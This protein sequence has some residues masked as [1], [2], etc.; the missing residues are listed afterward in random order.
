MI[1]SLYAGLL[2]LLFF[3]I[4]METIK[5]RRKHQVSLGVGDHHEVTAMVSAHSNFTSYAIYFLFLLYLAE[6]SEVIPAL[7]LHLVSIVFLA[8]RLFHFSAFRSE[9]MNFKQRVLG[10]QMTLFPL[11]FM[12][13]AN[14]GLFIAD[15]VG[16]LPR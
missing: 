5:A 13:A 15:K 7:L 14:I 12:C 11:L 1:T 10:M 9:K 2:G 3:K 6:A 4:T 8:G 16:F